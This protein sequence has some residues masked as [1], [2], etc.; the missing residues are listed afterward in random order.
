[1]HFALCRLYCLGWMCTNVQIDHTRSL[2]T[3]G[4]ELDDNLLL[5]RL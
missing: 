1:M 5:S 2:K 4:D 3:A